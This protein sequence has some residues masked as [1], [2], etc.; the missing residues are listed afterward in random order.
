MKRDLAEKITPYISFVD[1]T[2][3]AASALAQSADAHRDEGLANFSLFPGAL[4]RSMYNPSFGV[5]VQFL[6]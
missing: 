3:L 6:T 4:A 1:K 2:Y 5:A